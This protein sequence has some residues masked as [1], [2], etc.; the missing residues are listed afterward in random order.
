M[1]HVIK[2]Q[3]LGNPAHRP[4]RFEQQ[5][6]DLIGA[7][8]ADFFKDGMTYFRAKS[9]L[10]H[11]SGQPG[12]LGHFI[13]EHGSARVVPNETQRLAR[14]RSST[15][16]TSVERRA[17]TCVAATLIWNER[18]FACRINFSRAKAAA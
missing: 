12:M 14:Q 3:R 13:D 1:L 17:T 6:R 9:P 10:E 18:G 2:P 5:L 8:A 7:H 15:A 11:P 4:R 16:T